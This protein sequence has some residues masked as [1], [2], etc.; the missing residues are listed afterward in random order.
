[1]KK[2]KVSIIL[3]FLIVVLVSIGCIFMFTGI[4]FMPTTLKLE[5]SS[6]IM[7]KYFTVDSNIL[8]ALSSL[9]LVIYER[10]LINKEIKTIPK[11]VYI[12]KLVG[13]SAVALTFLVTLLFLTPQFGFLAMYSNN[14][15]IFH[16]IVPLL[17]IISYV[18][19]E[20]HNNKYRYAFLGIIPMLI[21]SIYY[22]LNVLIHVESGK[23]SPVYD[24]YGFLQGNINNVYY[25]VPMIFLITLIISLVLVM[26]NKKYSK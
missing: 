8:M 22:I 6:I 20:K 19:F 7:F 26:L 1:M 10:K 17:S 11:G 3:N 14:N 23:I 16:L 5:S 15:L 4:N 2:K 12:F 21:Y 24:F 18:F 25:V 9:L 13:T